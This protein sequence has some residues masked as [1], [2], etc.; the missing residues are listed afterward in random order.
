MQISKKVN[1]SAISARSW[2]KFGMIVGDRNLD[3]FLEKYFLH[4]SPN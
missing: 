4:P 2:T 1:K 3:E